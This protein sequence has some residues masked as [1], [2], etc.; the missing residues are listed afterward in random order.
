MANRLANEASP[1]L[2]MHADN[3]VDWYPWGKEALQKAVDENKPILLS[4]GYTACHWCH[5]MAHESFEDQETAQIM[6]QL[7]I[8]IKVDREERPDLDKIYQLSA[9]LLTRQT[10][11]WPL[12]V[13]LMPESRIP[14]FAGTYF[15]N[16]RRQQYPSFGEVLHY[17]SSVFHTQRLELE[18]QNSSFEKILNELES[19]AKIQSR[20]IF[21]FPLKAAKNKLEAEYD[22]ENGGFDG[23]P[24]FPMTSF[25]EF[26]SLFAYVGDGTCKNILINTLLRMFQGGLYDQLGGGFFRYS[27]DEKW[28]IPHFEKML[29]DNGLLLTL[30]SKMMIY[31]SNANFTQESLYLQNA[32]RG[33]AEW[34]INEMQSPEGGLFSSLSADTE[35]KEGKYYIWTKEEIKNLLDEREYEVISSYY[36][37]SHYPNFQKSWHLQIRTPTEELSKKHNLKQ[38]VLNALIKRAN[39]KL[40]K[41]RKNRVSPQC[42]DKIIVSW[43]GL[44]IKGLAL[45]GLMLDEQS[46]IQ[47]AK[48]CIDFIYSHLWKENQ[49]YSVYK[50][51]HAKQ[52]A[53]LDDYV[54][55]A[56]GIFN[57]LQVDWNND[58]YVFLLQLLRK[59]D[60]FE[61]K[62][63]GGLFFT[64][65]SHENLI[66]RLKQ[67]ADEAI[68]SSN[69]IVTSLLIQLSCLQGE[70]SY[71]DIAERSL[72]NAFPHIEQH[73]DVY[74]SF[75]IA[76]AYYFDP[77][78]VVIVRGSKDALIAWRKLFMKY[79]AP[80]RIGFFIPNE[81]E[82]PPPLD[83]KK[84]SGE[85]I[86]YFCKGNHCLA[87]IKTLK[88]FEHELKSNQ[89]RIT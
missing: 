38:D 7:F 29:Y 63:S 76:L 40:L 6:N 50:D 1:Y 4:I 89:F 87:P 19:Q 78:Q 16:V 41:A 80:N 75:L 22:K 85:S 81:T 33:T 30:Y 8:N 58:Y 25:L 13:F 62:E 32:I 71:F 42:D 39:E 65:K 10:G 24:K 73:A 52:V 35:G 11:G 48:K 66:Y 15:P 77:S 88:E 12:T 3:P 69:G 53:N 23:A 56:E 54:F 79:Y 72:K 46:Y 68:P 45:A 86:A 49:L 82:L 27:V 61:D 34:L 37:I 60:E 43:N 14:F 74:C 26:L 5:V 20:D 57:F 31:L 21:A 18:K 59:L 64:S 83:L 28:Q 70:G 47:S 51:Q 67:Y 17:V 9:Q 36:G 44:A 55:L 2:Q 84:A